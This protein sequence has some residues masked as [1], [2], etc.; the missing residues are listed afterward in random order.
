MHEEDACTI[1]I[2]GSS[3]VACAAFRRVL[4]NTHKRSP[5]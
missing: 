3:E 5:R 2:C 1:A 4:R